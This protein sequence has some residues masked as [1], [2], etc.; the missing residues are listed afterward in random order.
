MNPICDYKTNWKMSSWDQDTHLTYTNANIG[1][2]GDSSGSVCA[3]FHATQSNNDNLIF[4]FGS[5]NTTQDIS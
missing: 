5:S 4:S 3:S 1:I 2:Q